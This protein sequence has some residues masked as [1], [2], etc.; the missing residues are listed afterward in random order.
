M[1]QVIEHLQPAVPKVC[2]LVEDA[3]EDLLAFYAFPTTH[4][5]KLRS[6]NPLERVNREIGRRSDVVGIF[7]N[8]ASAIRLAGAL[9]IEQ[10]DE[11]LVC[12]RYL[13][14]QCGATRRCP[15]AEHRDRVRQRGGDHAR[16]RLSREPHRRAGVTP[17]HRLE[18]WG[19]PYSHA[20]RPI[21]SGAALRAG[22]HLT[23]TNDLVNPAAFSR[24]IVDLGK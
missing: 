17:P 23:A 9:L 18:S 22:G 10:N 16:R 3:E 15:R 4:W 8:D 12:R 2:R 19:W 14:R 13:R 24:T 1:V 21:V 20:R 5:S 7:P 11:W 6:A